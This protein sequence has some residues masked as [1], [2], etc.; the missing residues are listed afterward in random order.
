MRAETSAQIHELLSTVVARGPWAGKRFDT[1]YRRVEFKSGD[2]WYWR[3]FITKQGYGRVKLGD[4]LY[5]AHKVSYLVSVGDV[6]VGLELDHMCR[7]R[8]CVNPYHMEPIPGVTN[9][10]EGVSPS[11]L[12]SRKTHCKRGHALNE[13]NTY[14]DPKKANRSCRVCQRLHSETFRRRQGKPACPQ[15]RN[16]RSQSLTT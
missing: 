12:N 7:T 16:R 4:R 10:L 3:G 14:S 5:Y 6:P 1:F 11:G 8:D 9:M 2:C 15:R 13:G